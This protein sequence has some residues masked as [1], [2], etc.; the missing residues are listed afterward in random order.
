[1]WPSIY[2]LLARLIDAAHRSTIVFA[3]DRR[4]RRTHHGGERVWKP[5]D[6]KSGLQA[7]LQR[8][9]KSSARQVDRRTHGSVSRQVG[10][11]SRSAEGGQLPAVARRRR[12][13]WASTWGRSIW[14][15]R[16]R[17]R[18]TSPG[19]CSASAGRGTWSGSGARAGSS[20]GRP[21]DLLEQAVLVRE[22]LAAGSSDPRA[23]QLPRRAG[24]AS[25]GLVAMDDWRCRSCSRW[26]GGR[27]RTAR[28][29]RL[30]SVLEMVRGRFRFSVLEGSED[31]QATT[32][33]LTAKRRRQGT[34]AATDL[35][36]GEEGFPALGSPPM[37]P[38]ASSDHSPSTSQRCCSGQSARRQAG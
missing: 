9:M 27:T 4:I 31:G 29:P 15:A 30:D 19:A 24:A 22:M 36:Q 35:T 38:T 28:L 14:C 23:D 25:G 26:C 12:W 13:S 32:G 6:T 10:S 5:A 18:A 33:R 37:M 3:N 34:P 1:M 17:R 7:F 16:S 21:A 11:R 8:E 20:R 2:R